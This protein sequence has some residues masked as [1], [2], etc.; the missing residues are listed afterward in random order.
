M[1]SP[2]LLGLARVSTEHQS[3]DQQTDSLVAAGVPAERIYSDKASG[4]AG[5]PR[6]GLEALLTVARAGDVIVVVG[7]DR[8]GRDVPEMSATLRDLRDRGITVRSLR[9]GLDSSTPVGEAMLNLLIAIG[10]IEL[11]LAKERRAASRVAR[12]AR[13]QSIG[14]PKALSPGKAAQL[15]R[16]VRAGEPVAMAAEAFGISRASAYRIVK[17]AALGEGSAEGAVA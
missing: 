7:A 4:S 14:R 13:G 11:A 16:L 2:Y 8:L 12:K 15:V 9:E 3:L 6:P 5:T 1:S 10:G 17:E